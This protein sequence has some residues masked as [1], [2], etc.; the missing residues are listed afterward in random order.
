MRA[1]R[2]RWGGLYARHG[3]AK[4]TG[5]HKAR[6]TFSAVSPSGR[7]P[8][9]WQLKM[10]RRDHHP[11]PQ[12]KTMGVDAL[13]SR[14][15]REMIAAQLTR[16]RD[17]YAGKWTSA[18]VEDGGRRG[19]AEASIALDVVRRVGRYTVSFDGPLLGGRSPKPT[20]YV[21][22]LDQYDAT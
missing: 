17:Q 16:F 19:T 11:F 14:V 9:Q 15:E 12:I 18:W 1:L 7:S 2:K 21:V 22:G 5:G 3:R 8:L 10:K 20:T 4:K 13:R 6:P